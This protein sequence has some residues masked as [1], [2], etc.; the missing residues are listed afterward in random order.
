MKRERGEGSGSQRTSCLYLPRPDA[1]L[2]ARVPF[3][4]AYCS[5]IKALEMSMYVCVCVQEGMGVF[6]L[7]IGHT[8]IF[9]C[10]HQV[11]L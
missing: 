3:R 10:H 8:F 9:V 2:S 6:E 1:C 5:T 11:A 4:Q 7:H